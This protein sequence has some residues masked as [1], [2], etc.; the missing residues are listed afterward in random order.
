MEES[1]LGVKVHPSW[2]PQWR[3]RPQGVRLNSGN[4]PCVTCACCTLV[5]SYCCKVTSS[6]V[7]CRSTFLEGFQVFPLG[8]GAYLGL[9]HN[10]FSAI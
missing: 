5:C 8:K 9:L 3:R 6:R 2:V 4:N 10:L 7:W 1:D